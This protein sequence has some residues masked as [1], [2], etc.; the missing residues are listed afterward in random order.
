M[1]LQCLLLP[2]LLPLPGNQKPRYQL[3]KRN[4]LHWGNLP[5][6]AHIVLKGPTRKIQDFQISFSQAIFVPWIKNRMIHAIYIHIQILILGKIIICSYLFS[7]WSWGGWGLGAFLR[8][9][10]PSAMWAGG[11]VLYSIYVW[12]IPS[13]QIWDYV[14]HVERVSC[15]ITNCSKHQWAIPSL[16][17]IAL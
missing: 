17:S 2:W 8:W 5:L 6:C 10:P 7:L 9:W 1:L 11:W 12:V 3:Y 15:V 16:F 13:F 4:V 14:R